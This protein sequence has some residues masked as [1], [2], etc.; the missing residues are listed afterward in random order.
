MT[1][2]VLVPREPTPEMLSAG[3]QELPFG[4][5][6]T[7]SAHNCYRAMLSSAPAPSVGREEIARVMDPRAFDHPTVHPQHLA[8]R[9]KAAM[10]KAD[11]ILTLL[12]QHPRP[13]A[14][15]HGQAARVLA[16][17]EGPR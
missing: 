15:S 7:A 3:L 12:G 10:S 5:S 11:A 14:G 13:C 1:D 6:S 17:S 4:P 16:S 9:R 8:R 2:M